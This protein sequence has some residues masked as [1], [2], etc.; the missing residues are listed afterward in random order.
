MSEVPAAAVE[1]AAK[2]LHADYGRAIEDWWFYLDDAKDILTAAAPLIRQATA[3][4]V[5]AV[6]Q[7]EADRMNFVG[8]TEGAAVLLDALSLIARRVGGGGGGGQ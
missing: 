7:A 1:A 3:D 4:E 5:K 8:D 6:I 2:V